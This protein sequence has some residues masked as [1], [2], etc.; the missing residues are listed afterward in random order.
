MRQ[1]S[2]PK[3]LISYWLD[4]PDLGNIVSWTEGVV[5]VTIIASSLYDFKTYYDLKSKK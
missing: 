1:S 3:E 2:L 5:R 4:E